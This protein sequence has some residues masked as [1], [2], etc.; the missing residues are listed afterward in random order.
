MQPDVT[1]HQ[2]WI[3]VA[4]PEN[5]PQGKAQRVV[6][7]SSVDVAA[8]RSIREA[9]EGLQQARIS[10]PRLRAGLATY[11]FASGS[12]IPKEAVDLAKEAL[13]LAQPG[14]TVACAGTATLAVRS[15][16]RYE[17]K[18]IDP[19]DPLSG[20]WMLR[21]AG[22]EEVRHLS[23][24]RTP[25]FVGRQRDLARLKASVSNSRLVTVVGPSGIGKSALVDFFALQNEDGFSDGVIPVA[26]DDVQDSEL[27]WMRLA[28]RCEVDRGAFE[29][30]ATAVLSHLSTRSLLLILDGVDARLGIAQEAAR[31]IGEHCLD[32]VVLATAI[33][34]LGL[35]QEMVFPLCGMSLP[36]WTEDGLNTEE[37]D[38]Y[39]FL[40][41][42]VE[43]GGTPLVPSDAQREQLAHICTELEGHPVAITLAADRLGALSPGQLHGRLERRS[44]LLVNGKFGPNRHRSLAQ[45]SEWTRSQLDDVTVKV[46]DIACSFA[47]GFDAD[48]VTFLASAAGLT[49]S[50]VSLALATL[51]R[52]CLAHPWSSDGDEVLLTIDRNLAAYSRSECQGWVN[53]PAMLE[54]RGLLIDS[55]LDDLEQASRG[56]QPARWARRFFAYEEDILAQAKE[57]LRTGAVERAAKVAI[58]CGAMLVRHGDTEKAMA[59]IDAVSA[60]IG[61]IPE[62]T[63]SRVLSTRAALQ[64]VA[65]DPEAAR[66]TAVLALRMARKAGNRYAEGA[67]WG[68]LGLSYRSL[69]RSSKADSCLVKSVNVH[70]G[71]GD[72]SDMITPVANWLGLR[73]KPLD[74]DAIRLADEALKAGDATGNPRSGIL[75]RNNLACALSRG[76]RHREALLHAYRAV[77]AASEAGETQSFVRS[78]RTLGAIAVH[79]GKV[80]EGVE[81]LGAAMAMMPQDIGEF[82]RA[83]L[84]IAEN[85]LDRQTVESMI[86][87]SGHLDK[88]TVIEQA[89]N[90]A[91]SFK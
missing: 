19:T 62:H 60:E 51:T 9:M 5:P 81:L 30:L 2:V 40:M 83:A 26:L 22:D 50:D 29:S 77:E 91:N 20:F 35:P 32:V 74:E 3:V 33:C 17:A 45:F 65:Q 7:S 79:L 72:P 76:G 37:S 57:W 75:L 82:D 56:K 43:R 31:L 11:E 59:L 16:L 38:A 34:P 61:R 58:T 49:E 10:R 12:A 85:V 41:Q 8:Y 28:Q 15:G 80:E 48:A 13:A 70:R 73:T 68:T 23:G 1:Q 36:E 52:C 55:M 88:G 18:P 64:L 27:L 78:V 44:G 86:L 21:V 87:I 89:G 46:L 71:S 42:L 4:T 47:I 24:S 63:R 69:E 54:R 25:L 14:N 67:A 53:S 39:R 84:Q 90:L 6:S 66:F